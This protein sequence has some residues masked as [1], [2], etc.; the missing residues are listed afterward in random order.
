[1]SEVWVLKHEEASCQG[2]YV[3][4]LGV[5]ATEALAREAAQCDAAIRYSGNSNAKVY[6]SDGGASVSFGCGH[7]DYYTWDAHE[8]HHEAQG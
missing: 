3:E 1:M 8:V 5:Y 2:G 6:W 4:T 7:S